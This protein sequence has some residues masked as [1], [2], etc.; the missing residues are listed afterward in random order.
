MPFVIEK[1]LDINAP[2][3]VVWEVISDLPRYPQWNPFCVEC[4]STL[5]PGDPIDMKVQLMAKPQA[6]REWMLEFIDG[7]RFAYRM[8]PVPL[9]ALSSFR[10]HD[11]EATGAATARYRSY[12]HLKGWMKFVVLGLFRSKLEDGF[13]GMSAA[14]KARAESLWAQRQASAAA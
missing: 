2:A 11:I 12:F 5:V 13:A 9:G 6:Q 4:R 7:Q 1:T 14:I 10:S 3:A 8:K